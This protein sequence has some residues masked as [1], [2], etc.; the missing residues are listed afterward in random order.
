MLVVHICVEGDITSCQAQ[1]NA[2]ITKFSLLFQE[3]YGDDMDELMSKL[4]ELATDS[5]KYR[6]K[7]DRRQQRSSF[8]DIMKTIEVGY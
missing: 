1:K 3:F 4:K 8:R 7:K 2:A 6:A 5:N